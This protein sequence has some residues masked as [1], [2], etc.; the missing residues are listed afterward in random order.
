MKNYQRR[1]YQKETEGKKEYKAYTK[2]AF[3][4]LS[5]K[6]FGVGNKSQKE[7]TLCTKYRRI[8]KN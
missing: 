5:T 6:N 8:K 2:D 3:F 4:Y 1:T 7:D